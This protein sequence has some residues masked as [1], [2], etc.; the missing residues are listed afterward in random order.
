MLNH[1]KCIEL[2]WHIKLDHVTLSRCSLYNKEEGS[3]DK[4]IINL[5][6]LSITVDPRYAFLSDSATC[7]NFIQCHVFKVKLKP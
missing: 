3:K 6:E 5:K 4:V 7:T 1:R 2:C